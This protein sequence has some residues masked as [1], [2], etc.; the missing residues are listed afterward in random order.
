[1]RLHQALISGCYIYLNFKLPELANSCLYILGG[2]G[3]V[4]L[5]SRVI[6]SIIDEYVKNLN[7]RQEQVKF[8]G[9][10]SIY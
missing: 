1:M 10:I 2:D 7:N 3:D 4:E 8:V 6:T 5:A 9:F